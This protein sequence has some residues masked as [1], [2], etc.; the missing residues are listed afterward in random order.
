M[1]NPDNLFKKKPVKVNSC[2]QSKKTKLSVKAKVSGKVKAI[3]KEEPKREE[4]LEAGKVK[5]REKC[6]R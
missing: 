6:Y 3:N 4:I 5:V 2:K 1:V